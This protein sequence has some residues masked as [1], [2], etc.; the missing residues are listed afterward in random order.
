M[1]KAPEELV[2]PVAG[3]Q[4]RGDWFLPG[5]PK[6][7]IIFAHGSGSSRKSSRNIAVARRFQSLRFEALLFDLLTEK[8]EQE[9]RETRHLRFDIELLSSRLAAVSHYMSRFDGSAGLPQGFFGASTGGAAALKA[10]IDPG[11]Q[12]KAVVSRG[13]R[14]DLA[15]ESLPRVQ[16]PTLL[17]VGSMDATVLKLNREAY[18]ELKCEKE[19]NIIAGATHLFEEP[20]ALEEVAQISGEWFERFLT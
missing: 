15:E 16:A 17:I 20:G 8:E 2:I 19:L 10:S 14:P 12:A 7:L 1:S 11:A 18:A 13:G 9:E 6:G 4:L 3:A 5:A